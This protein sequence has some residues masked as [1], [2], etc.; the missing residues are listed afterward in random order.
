MSCGSAGKIDCTRMQSAPATENWAGGPSRV[1][2]RARMCIFVAMVALCGCSVNPSYPDAGNVAHS[3]T[4]CAQAAACCAAMLASEGDTTTQCPQSESMCESL[5][6]DQQ[7]EYI[8]DC[9][10]VL[11]RAPA[12]A[13]ACR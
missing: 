6:L 4:D 12:D 3:C 2:R 5:P 9:D 13:T 10:A 1:P 11:G 7:Q 8:E